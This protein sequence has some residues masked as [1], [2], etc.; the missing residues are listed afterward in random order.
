MARIATCYHLEAKE[1]AFAAI[2]AEAEKH[3]LK[4]SAFFVDLAERLEERRFHDDAEKYFRET[5]E[6]DIRLYEW[7]V[8][9][10]LPRRMG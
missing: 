1:K 7:L 2:V 3:N 9:E 5:N 6:W 10:Y 4:P 8:R